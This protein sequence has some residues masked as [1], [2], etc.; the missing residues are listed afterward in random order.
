MAIMDDKH[1]EI[2][3]IDIFPTCGSAVAL[4]H[5]TTDDDG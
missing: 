3:D 1:V 2:V 4:A 5:F